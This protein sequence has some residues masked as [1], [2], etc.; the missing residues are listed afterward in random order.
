VHL[1][2]KVKWQIQF[3]AHIIRSG[4][5]IA[6]PTET[7]WGLACDPFNPSAVDA[8]LRLKQ[9]PIEKGLILVSGQH[10]H[11]QPLLSLLSDDLQARFFQRTE[12]PTT[13]LV[14]DTKHLVPRHIKGV[15]SSAALRLSQDLLITELSGVLGHPVISTSANPAGREPAKSLFQVNQYFSSKI[16]YILYVPAVVTV[17]G[18]PSE[19]RDLTTNKVLR[20]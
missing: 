15:Y 7:V 4:G 20:S 19:I 12:R 10:S 18:R 14:P 16:D 9:R 11:F 5:V 8:L 13:W 3:A 17:S 6:H 1:S 2:K